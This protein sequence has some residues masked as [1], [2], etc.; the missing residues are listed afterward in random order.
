[1]MKPL[2]PTLAGDK[3]DA[4]FGGLISKI[5][6]EQFSVSK[7]NPEHAAEAKAHLLKLEA[8][9]EQPENALPADSAG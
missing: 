4:D 3:S 9:K 1:M 7:W 2:C 8:K 6:R 5:Y